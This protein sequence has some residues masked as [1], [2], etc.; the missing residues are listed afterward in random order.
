MLFLFFI[1]YANFLHII[2]QDGALLR[3][4]MWHLFQALF[5][6]SEAAEKCKFNFL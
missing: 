2:F 5:V 1:K 3:M 4:Q 6:L